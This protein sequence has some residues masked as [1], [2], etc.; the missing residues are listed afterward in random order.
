MDRTT[1]SLL[2][3]LFVFCSVAFSGPAHASPRAVADKLMFNAGD[4]PQGGVIVHDF[5]LKNTGG[6]PLTLEVKSCSCGG[7]K[8][9][10]PAAPIAPGKTGKIRVSIPTQYSRGDLRKDI[11]VE[12]NDPEKKS[13]I[14]TVQG[15]IYPLLTI[16]P[17]VI[18]F[19]KVRPGTTPSK[20]FALANKGKT[21]VVIPLIETDPP[22][23]L[24]ASPQGKITLQPGERKVFTLTL[25]PGKVAGDIVGA[26]IVRTT[27]E[28]LPEIR[29]KAIAEVVQ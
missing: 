28:K 9:E 3:F 13:L 11:L 7:V 24:K 19:G 23:R 25:D 1:A 29:V 10:T 5:V 4:V 14:F 22:A 17:L 15:R 27:L 12:T 6:D 2:V 18:V 16:E 20:G 21:P 8:Y 26:L